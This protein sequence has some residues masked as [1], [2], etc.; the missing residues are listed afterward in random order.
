[1][2][3]VV[4]DADALIAITHEEDANHHKALIIATKL[5]EKGVNV[6]FPNTAI[7]E[8]ITA[9]KRAL[10]LPEK[11]ALVNKQYQQGVFVVEYVNESIQMLASEYYEKAVSKQNTAFDAVVAACAKKLNADAI[12]SF[13][14][15]YKKQGFK[16]VSE[17]F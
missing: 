11:S 16:L 5:L 9:L 2:R 13:D 7:L 8:A 4:S 3:I 1:M 15:W 17:L 6:I 14:T 10:N 12:F